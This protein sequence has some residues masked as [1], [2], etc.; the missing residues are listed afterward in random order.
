MRQTIARFHGPWLLLNSQPGK[1]LR[2]SFTSNKNIMLV[3][4]EFAISQQRKRKDP[5]SLSRAG[6][7]DT[8]TCSSVSAINASCPFCKGRKS[9]DSK[10]GAKFLHAKPVYDMYS[11]YKLQ[12]S[13]SS[14]HTDLIAF[15]VQDYLIAHP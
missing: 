9:V 12:E 15:F 3:P 13:K 10:I 6:R 1:N 5:S 7:K 8:A 4:A 14:H 2:L 11:S